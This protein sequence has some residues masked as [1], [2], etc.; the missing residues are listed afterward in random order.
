MKKKGKEKKKKK[1]ESV[2]KRFDFF[3]FGM[4]SLVTPLK[5]WEDIKKERKSR[6][7]KR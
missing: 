4:V 3:F 1:K 7:F 5:K 6:D 2:R